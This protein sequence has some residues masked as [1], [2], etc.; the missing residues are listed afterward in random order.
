MF[1]YQ[2]IICLFAMLAMA[3]VIEANSLHDRPNYWPIIAGVKKRSGAFGVM[4]QA[5]VGMLRNPDNRLQNG[6]AIQYI[7]EY[8]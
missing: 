3:F 2:A 7:Y 5:G 1:R 8:E 6:P 4:G